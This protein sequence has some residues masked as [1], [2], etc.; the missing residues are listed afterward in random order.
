[1]NYTV[2]C[3]GED[4]CPPNP[5]TTDNTTRSYNITNLTTMI[6]Y[7]FS[8]VATNSIGSGQAGTL[9][10]IIEGKIVVCV[11][12]EHKLLYSR[13]VWQGYCLVN[14]PIK[15]GCWKKLSK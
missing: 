12:T 3:S 7:T 5:S 4:A 13:N 8:V 15:S 9:N 14:C 2:S 1:M 6:N 11:C 10:Y